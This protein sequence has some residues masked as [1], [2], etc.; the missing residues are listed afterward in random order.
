MSKVYDWNA[1]RN[2]TAAR[3]AANIA[4]DYQSSYHFDDE[5]LVEKAISIA[6]ILT[7]RL[8][9]LENKVLEE[10]KKSRR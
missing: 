5:R 1:F 7:I 6:S 8:L 4:V 9:E 2:E 10:E 3:I